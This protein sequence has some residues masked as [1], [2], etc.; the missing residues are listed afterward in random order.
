M[1]KLKIGSDPEM[2]IEHEGKIISVEGMLGGTKAAPLRLTDLGEGFAVQEDNV[3]AEFN[4]PATDNLEDFIRY[5]ELMPKAIEYIIFQ[6]TG[7]TVSAL[8]IASNAFEEGELVSEQAL[9][10]GCDPDINIWAMEFNESPNAS[11]LIRSAGGHLH[12]GWDNPTMEEQINLIKFMDLY[13]GL[14]S[15]IHDTDLLRKTLYGKAG[16][17]RFKSYGVEYRSVSNF[18]LGSREH[19][20][21]VFHLTNQ[22]FEKAM[23][24][25]FPEELSIIEDVINYNNVEKALELNEK[26][27][28]SLV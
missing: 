20:S 26:Y 21:K 9:L 14:Y 22:A 2:F 23:A 1:K 15:V 8:P 7:K 13:V 18:W 28:L 11:S 27:N 6:N 24:I 10:F 25:N 17:C 16:S 19:M 4:V 12:C 3:L 5:H